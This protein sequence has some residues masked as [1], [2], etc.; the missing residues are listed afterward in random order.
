LNDKIDYT[1]AFILEIGSRSFV[2]KSLDSVVG[3]GGIKM[4]VADA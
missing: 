3:T 1:L 2:T 4:P